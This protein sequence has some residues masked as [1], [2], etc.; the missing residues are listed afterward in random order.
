VRT[1]GWVF[2]YVAT[3]IGLLGGVYWAVSSFE[4]AGSALLL[5]TSALASVVSTYLLVV[6]RGQPPG[7]SDR[8]DAQPGDEPGAVGEFITGSIWPFAIGVAGTVLAAGLA[9]GAL[10][11]VLGVSLVIL[12]T[13][14]LVAE[15]WR[16]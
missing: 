4:S 5:L 14:A 6:T 13:L 1:T 2:T 12:A 3:F 15:P 16:R 9:F 7:A 10:P 8:A 11:I